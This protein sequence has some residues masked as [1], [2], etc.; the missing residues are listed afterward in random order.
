[1]KK[2]QLVW[3]ILLFCLTAC[4][5]ILEVQDI[6]NQQVELLAPTNGAQVN[7]SVVRFS[8]NAVVEA[9]GYILQV[10]RPNFENAAQF[11][12]DTIIV[13][14]ST[15]V[16]TRYTQQLENSGYEWRVKAYNSGFETGFSVNAFQVGN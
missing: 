7:D 14:D 10:A 13:I 15:F 6:S 3:V 8:W 16:G 4:E 1:M 2:Q 9:D 12:V 5:E 11:V